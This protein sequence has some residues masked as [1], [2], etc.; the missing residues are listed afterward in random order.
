VG[1][2]GTILRKPAVAGQFYPDAPG[3]LIDAIEGCVRDAGHPGET[4]RHVVPAVVAPHAGYRYSGAVAAKVFDGVDLPRRVLV[5]GPNHTGL[6]PL[7]SI[8]PP[9]GVWRMPLGDVPIDRELTEALLDEHPDLEPEQTAHVYEH[10]IEVE[11]PFLQH[12]GDQP[13][14][15]AI[16]LRTRRPDRMRALGAA[17]ARALARIEEPVLLVAS[18][19]MNHFQDYETTLRKDQLAIDR[20]LAMD[21]DGLLETCD[22]E[23]ISMCGAGPTAAVIH[24]I[25]ARGGGHAELLEHCTSGDRD[26]RRDRVVGYV[27]MRLT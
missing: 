20:M 14:I 5:I 4:A 11:L 21:P 19:D 17:I 24:A 16:V 10:G 15:A 22:Q 8:F 6:G 3:R 7:M 26:G 13:Q 9:N 25:L 27:G 23:A 12:L 18:T 1:E 2:S